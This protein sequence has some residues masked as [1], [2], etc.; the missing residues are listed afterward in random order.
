MKK[1]WNLPNQLTLGR[2][3]LVPVVLVLLALET[4]WS[5]FFAFVVFAVASFTDLVDGYLARRG[6]QVTN[7][8]KLLDPLADKVLVTSVL[9]MLV[10]LDWVSAWIAIIIICRDMMVTGLRAMAAD[11]GI[12]I[13]ADKYGKLKTILQLMALGPL[14]LH[15][16]W[17][18]LPLET[19]GQIL[20][21][22]ALVL[23]VFSGVNY[24]V[25]FF[26]AQYS[27]SGA[28]KNKSEEG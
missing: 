26:K 20:L 1:I 5:C 25:L 22:I 19:I 15:Y 21:Y 6:G 3:L 17:L 27:M 14:I 9:I 24:F 16:P 28:S 2:I 13:A 12:V 4:K 23:T 11:S 7:L 8:G 10:E 18:G